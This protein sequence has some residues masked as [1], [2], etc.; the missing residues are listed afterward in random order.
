MSQIIDFDRKM[1][2]ASAQQAPEYLI[3]LQAQLT[4]LQQENSALRSR[5][6]ACE[7]P[8]PLQQ[9]TGCTTAPEYRLLEATAQ[10][11]NT[12]LT[13]ANFDVAVNS[14]LQ[15]LGEALVTNRVKVLE[16]VFED[17]LS[18]FPTAS[19]VIYEWVTPGTVSQMT[20]PTSSQI[21]A[22]DADRAFMNQVLYKGFGG[23]LHEWDRTLWDAFEAVQA[24]AIYCVPIWVQDQIWGS[25][26]FDD[27]HEVKQRSPIEMS[28]LKIGANCIGS[29]IQRDR[30]QQALL[31]SEQAR[32]RELEYLNAELQQT[33]ARLSESEQ[34]YRQL[35][36]LASEG[37]F[38]VHYEQPIPINLP[39]E[40]QA[41]Q[42]YQQFRYVEHN[43]AFAQM[44]GYDQPNAMVGSRLTDWHIADA[45]EN[46]VQMEQ[47][48]RNGHQMRN[49]ETVEVDRF[50]RKRHFL[51]NGFSIIRDGYAIGGW[52]TQI[53][54]TELREA[55][56]A[57]LEAEQAQVAQ[58]AEANEKLQ[59]RDRLLS[60]VAEVTKDL[61]EN[62]QVEEAIVQ[63]FQQ[64]GEVSG[65]SRITLMQE[66]LEACS[67]RLQH[68][69]IQEWTAPGMPR[70]ID[71]PLTKVVYNDEYGVLIDELHVG[72]SVWHVLEGFP[73][74]ARTQQAAIAV[75]STGAVP[76]FIEGA[77]FGCV[78]FDDCVTHREWTQQEIDVLSSG[79]GAIGAALHRKQLVDRLVDERTQAEQARAAELV[80]ANN[81]LRRSID[82]LMNQ[83]SVEAFL[84]VTLRSIAEVLEVSSA[85]L[86]KIEENWA[87]LQWV[88][89]DGQVL[90]GDQTD[91]S[92]A[93]TPEPLWDA[94][95]AAGQISDS[96]F[97]YPVDG[98]A[99]QFTEAQR[100]MFHQLGVRSVLVAPIV[101]GDRTVSLI[102]ARL[103][104]EMP[105]PSSLRLELVNALTGQAA[106][107]LQMSQLAEEA[108]QAAVLDERNRMARDIHDSLA[109]SFTGIIMQ[110]EAVKSAAPTELTPVKASEPCDLQI[111]LDRISD[112]ARL[113]LSEARR[114][115]QALR[116]QVL[117]AANFA[118]ALQHLLHQ[119][120]HDTP[121][122]AVVH[123]EGTP[124]ALPA[125]IEENLLRITQ[126]A[127]T[128]AI[129]HG[130]A[131]TLTLQ[132]LFE[133]TAI[134]LQICDDGDG[135]DPQNIAAP[136]FGLVGMQERTLH[137]N[138]YFHLT[139]HPGQGTEVTVAI[140]VEA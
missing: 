120:T 111:R 106:L 14:A 105:D 11:A 108:K 118:D 104:H 39:V 4:V 8:Q 32:S 63:A 99:S 50:G 21:D 48:V 34:R 27:C 126:E 134:H 2:E 79:A 112:L 113:G 96:P 28:I 70:Q 26:I 65:I 44:Y 45:P 94:Y 42:I 76:I 125:T 116:P 123:V 109:Q 81:A 75:K 71:N 59:Q 78:G 80:Q 41:R 64:I 47:F 121:L 40:E 49:Q 98:P 60:V 77:Y 55:Q 62:S 130:H 74:P 5:L 56:Q 138:G 1:E 107:A 69:V 119:V 53:D 25:F 54:I 12:L 136:G 19:A 129:R 58:L 135:F 89:Q 18:A 67:G 9:S 100:A 115:V 46:V 61:L 7:Q 139:S 140:P 72:R 13:A 15:I 43:L 52:G 68:H 93:K 33:I 85:T 101:I 95:R 90:L 133:P 82:A 124:Y 29:A 66:K 117:E 91:H 38:R 24:K 86:W 83:P 20:H 51:N 88:Y 10:A 6:E 114:S 17:K 23:L 131:H 128:N 122:R 103:T 31:Q 57:L 16:H 137:L 37:I 73:E 22:R 102:T 30:T 84:E 87:T 110:L 97:C 36:E 132:L 35:M 127:L 3:N 92:N